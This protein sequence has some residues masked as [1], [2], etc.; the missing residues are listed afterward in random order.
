MQIYF[1]FLK[2]QSLF[3]LILNNIF[4]DKLFLRSY[5]ELGGDPRLKI[6]SALASCS[7]ASSSFWWGIPIAILYA[8]VFGLIMGVPTLRLRA[9]YLAIVTLG[10]G[11]IIRILAGSDML[12]G[13]LVAQ[14]FDRQLLSMRTRLAGCVRCRQRLQTQTGVDILASIRTEQHDLRRIRRSGK[15]P[16]N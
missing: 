1:L 15:R 10:F 4:N 3:R 6:S 14:R 7:R 12:K 16:A 2:T 5:S 13:V 8:V 11:E 9:D